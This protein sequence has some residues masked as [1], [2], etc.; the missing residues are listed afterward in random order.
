V[1]F[2]LLKYYRQTAQYDL[3]VKENIE[4]T[5]LGGP[6]GQA[7][8]LQQA[9]AQGGA[10]AVMEE[11]AKPKRSRLT[12][13]RLDSCTAAEASAMLGR[14]VAA[15]DALEQC[16]RD[17]ETALIYLKVDPVWTDIRSEPRFQELLRRIHLR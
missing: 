5:R 17:T 4:D 6:A 16:D 15:L 9:Y 7:Q 2:Y 3:W 14:N 8:S 11:L 1:H 10:R 13:V 12:G